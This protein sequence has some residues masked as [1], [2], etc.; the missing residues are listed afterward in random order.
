MQCGDQFLGVIAN[1]HLFVIDDGNGQG[2][3]ATAL[4]MFAGRFIRSDI[5][6][7]IPNAMRREEFLKRPAAESARVGVNV[8]VHEIS[9]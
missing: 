6:V 2:G 8:N 3:D 7:F 5:V 1:D 4:E 9:S